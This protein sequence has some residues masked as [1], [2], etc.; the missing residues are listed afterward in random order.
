MLKLTYTLYIKGVKGGYLWIRKELVN[1]L[2]SVEKIKK[3]SIEELMQIKGIN[4][5]LANKL[6]E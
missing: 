6:K 2:R 1:L 4:Q 3:A 5:E